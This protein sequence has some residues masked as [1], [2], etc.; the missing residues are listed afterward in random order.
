MLLEVKT[1][2]VP[3]LAFMLGSAGFKSQLP[4]FLL[5]LNVLICKIRLFKT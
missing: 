1:E 5:S 3:E 2:A 4:A